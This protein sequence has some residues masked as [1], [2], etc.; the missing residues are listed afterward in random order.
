[1]RLRPS[2]ALVLCLGPVLTSGCSPD[3]LP[4]SDPALLLHDS[5]P[6]AFYVEWVTTTDLATILEVDCGAETFEHRESTPRTEHRAFVMGLWP[7]VNC[8]VYIRGEGED[9]EEFRTEA[10]RFTAG[11]LPDHLPLIEILESDGAPRWTLMTMAR[12]GATSPGSAVIVDEQGRYRWLYERWVS[13]PAPGFDVRL[14]TV[15]DEDWGAIDSTGTGVMVG[16]FGSDYVPGIASWDGQLVWSASIDMHHEIREAGPDRLMYLGYDTCDGVE[17]NALFDLDL[18]TGATTTTWRSCDNLQAP[19]VPFDDWDHLNAFTFAGDDPSV[20]D[21]VVTSRN[22]DQVVW[23]DRATG[24]VRWTLG[25]DGDL[26]LSAEDAFIQPHGVDVTDEGTILLLD[27]G[28]VDEREISRALEIRPD[29]DAGTAEVVWSWTADTFSPILGAATRLDDGNTLVVLGNADA[30]PSEL[31][32]VTPGGAIAW[33]AQVHGEWATNRAQ[34]IDP[35]PFSVM[36]D[37]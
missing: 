37:P 11:E 22:L 17:T 26:T 33:H 5:N 34:R 12:E 8:D 3:E 29:E 18:A 23:L 36:M 24:Q 2:P 4:S 6:L 28:A 30:D 13:S 21:I 31:V 20:A 1:M 27:N 19:S 15:P 9:G 10:K 7:G 35:I 16:G 32:E 25:Q 14:V